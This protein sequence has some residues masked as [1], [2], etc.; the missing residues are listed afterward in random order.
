M[1][2]GEAAGKS[3][4]DS[5]RTGRFE[6]ASVAL[7]KIAAGCGSCHAKYRNVPQAR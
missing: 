6:A 2:E 3:L 4:K 7:G 1:R 5:L